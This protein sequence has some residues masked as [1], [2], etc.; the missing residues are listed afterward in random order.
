MPPE[1]LKLLEKA[2]ESL[3]AAE[4]HRSQGYAVNERLIAVLAAAVLS[5]LAFTGCHQK[6]LHCLSD[7]ALSAPVATN[8]NR[9]SA[10]LHRVFEGLGTGTSE[11]AIASAV[12]PILYRVGSGTY[13]KLYPFR[14]ML[15]EINPSF[16]T[17]WRGRH[18][19]AGGW[20]EV[21]FAVFTDT[22]K[23]NLADAFW[24]KDGHLTPLVDGLFDRNVRAVRPGDAIE[25]VY[26]LLGKRHG[27]YF[28]AANGKW[29]VRF[30]YWAYR[31]RV[32]LIEVDAAEGR[33]VY[34]AEGTI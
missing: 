15:P 25:T 28:R 1:V 18:V 26:R 30:I 29:R 6:K 34:A 4:L 11:Q 22:N 10:D 21:L 17:E 7:R 13:S 31:G 27:D 24:F 19:Q 23:T 20:P 12:E 3:A 2:R 9:S 14:E 8:T 32:F 5:L 16:L 33:V